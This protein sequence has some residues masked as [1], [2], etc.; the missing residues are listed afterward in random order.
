VNFAG[1]GLACIRGER[2]VFAD[3]S[4]RLESGGALLLTGANGSGK[5]SLL[6]LCAG[7]VEPAAGRLLWDGERL[8]VE[9]HRNRLRYVGHLDAVKSVLSVAEN[10][11]FWARLSGAPGNVPAALEQVGL[12]RLA[13]LPARLLSA[14]Q[15]RRLAL[16]RLALGRADL[17]LL[18]EPTV[19]LD[20]DGIALLAALV[21][22][23]RADG[24]MVMAATHVDT[25][26]A[27]TA[28]LSLDRFRPRRAA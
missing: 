4:F 12:A 17:W 15:K 9:L 2:M 22:A 28:E 5:S 7:L 11:A 21:A 10:L 18:D 1:D 13:D 3:L 6:R 25:G 14:G 8:D 19:G 16:A 20:R 24:G 23:H 26:F 27:A